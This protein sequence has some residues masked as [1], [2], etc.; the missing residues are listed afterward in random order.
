MTLRP[1]APRSMVN[2]ASRQRFSPRLPVEA[3]PEAE[4]LELPRLTLT[5]EDRPIIS[6]EPD[7]KPRRGMM[8]SVALAAICALAGAGAMTVYHALAGGVSLLH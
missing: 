2:P 3:P 6:G 8:R 4:S 1:I 5:A 7:G